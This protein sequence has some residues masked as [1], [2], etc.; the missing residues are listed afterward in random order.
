M[1][2]YIIFPLRMTN[3]TFAHSGTVVNDKGSNIFVISHFDWLLVVFIRCRL[4]SRCVICE[5]RSSSDSQRRKKTVFEAE[6]MR[7]PTIFFE[8]RSREGFGVVFGVVSSCMLTQSFQ[9]TVSSSAQASLC[10]FWQ[11]RTLIDENWD[12]PVNRNRQK[13]DL[14]RRDSSDRHPVSTRKSIVGSSGVWHAT[15]K[16]SF[17]R[18]TNESD[19]ATSSSSPCWNNVPKLFIFRIFTTK[20]A[21]IVIAWNASKIKSDYCTFMILLPSYG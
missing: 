4:L 2:R 9:M 18:K 5:W 10:C 13:T 21:N 1:Q 19:N 12:F 17:F 8:S 6:A 3:L 15:L 16:R 11:S 20:K 14:F 7:K